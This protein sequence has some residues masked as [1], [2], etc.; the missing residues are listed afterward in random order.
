MFE[1]VAV[2]GLGL[3]G[4][5]L[6]ARLATDRSAVGFDS[7]AGTRALVRDAGFEVGPDLAGTVAGADLVVLAVPLPA[8]PGVLDELR[9]ALPPTAVLTDVASVKG[10]VRAADPPGR[11]VGGHPMAGT[12]F[13]G[14]GAAD[15]DLFA[16]AAWVL[17]LDDGTDTAAWLDLAELVTGIGAAVVPATAEAHDQAVALVSGLP[18]LFA[19]TLANAAAG[20]EL[21]LSLAAGSFR[22]GTRVAGTRPVL[23]A[24]LC[25][26]NRAA[27]T[28]AMSDAIGDLIAIRDSLVSGRSTLAEFDRANAVLQ[29]LD[30]AG[31]RFDLPRN[32]PDLRGRLLDL[33]AAG[34]RVLAVDADRLRCE[35]P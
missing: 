34:G 28:E 6:L 22:D 29:L 25:D 18:H 8:I 31:T 7:D 24:A 32:D 10:P 2:V 9:T 35:S 33:G 13:S 17:C 26:W 11:Y 20:S 15:P 14:F 4:G 27:L 23:A 30:R 19:A 5:S 3:I 1:R 21:A 16:R 12:E